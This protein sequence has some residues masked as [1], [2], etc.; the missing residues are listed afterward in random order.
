MNSTLKTILLWIGL[1][2]VVIMLWKTFQ[3]GR[4][5]RHEVDFSE[6]LQSVS[7]GRVKEVTVQGN[8]L[9]GAFRQG[10]P[11]TEGEAFTTQLLD[12]PDL[13]KE[14]R[15]AGVR[16]R[17]EEPKEGTLLTIL[18]CLAPLI[19]KAIFSVIKTLKARGITIL[20]VEQMALQALKVADRAYV[21]KNGEI[22]SSGQAQD[23]LNDP[24]VREAYLG[25][26]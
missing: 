16:I 17:F 10:G 18:V 19:V 14:L 12:Y 9:Q 7:D 3:D 13:V 1:F 24:A 21:L 4:V 22:S 2:V 8:K 25:K 11:Y 5:T 23:M 6:F 15:A 20:L 26:H